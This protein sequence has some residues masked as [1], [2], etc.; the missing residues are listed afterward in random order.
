MTG[1][2]AS[3]DKGSLHPKGFMILTP[4]QIEVAADEEFSS[5]VTVWPAGPRHSVSASAPAASGLRVTVTG[6]KVTVTGCL[7]RVGERHSVLVTVR[8]G[9]DIA[10]DTL[11]V[12]ATE[13]P[14]A[15]PPH[16]VPM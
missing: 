6:H 5:S 4:S 8:D 15:T 2:Q 11:T 14:T 10:H 13:A 12:A 7:G 9:T 3:T 16:R 1:N